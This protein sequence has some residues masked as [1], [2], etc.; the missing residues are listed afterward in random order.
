MWPLPLSLVTFIYPVLCLTPSERIDHLDVAAY[1]IFEKPKLNDS[2]TLMK[3][4]NTFISIVNET[5]YKLNETKKIDKECEDVREQ[6]YPDFLLYDLN[7]KKLT[8]LKNTLNWNEEEIGKF[9]SLMKIAN[10]VW[11]EFLKLH[12]FFE[13]GEKPE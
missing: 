2:E 8:E 4:V 3:C 9:S 1:R 5:I 10:E 12:L 7:N 11:F 13:R 6:A